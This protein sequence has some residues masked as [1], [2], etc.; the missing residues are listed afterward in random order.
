MK[1]LKKNGFIEIGSGKFKVGKNL[2]GELSKLEPWKELQKLRI[3]ILFVHG[4][5]DT[6]VPYEDSVNY[7]KML[8]TSKLET[9]SGGGHGFYDN[10]E[11]EEEA[12]RVTVEFF[13]EN[14]WS[15]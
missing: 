2:F 6:Y 14:M 4:D 12:D 15:K 9:I 13:S 8:K 11:Q 7:S 5:K 1:K 3:P 10:K